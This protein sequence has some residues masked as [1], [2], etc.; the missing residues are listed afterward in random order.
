MRPVAPP[1]VTAERPLVRPDGGRTART[2]VR[3]GDVLMVLLALC[4]AAYFVQP[5]WFSAPGVQAWG[6][7]FA[8][9]CLQALPFLVLGVLVSAAVSLVPASFFERALPRSAVLAVPVA[10][11]AGAVLPGCECASVPVAGGLVRR[12]VA[13]AA[14]LA[15]LLSAPAINPVVVIATVVAFPDEP[16]MAVARFAASLLVAVV[17]GWV[18]AAFGRGDWLRL[19]QR[20][21]DSGGRSRGRQF[22]DVAQHDFVHAGGFLV[23]GGVAAATLNVLV[24]RAWLDAVAGDPVLAVLVLA[25]LA[26]VLSICSEADAFV[27]ASLTSFSLTSR[28]VFLVVGPVVDLK[29]IALQSGTFGPRFALRFAPVTFVVAVGCALLAAWIL[30]GGR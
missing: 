18:W 26:V 8:A 20:A 17:V 29:L 21:A 24:P 14:A 28:L 16:L 15:F 13:P 4:I 25:A 7:V 22:L 5:D 9:I 10:G 2:G 11:A 23:L 12:G 30:L 27:A 19:P 6:T 3:S 1:E